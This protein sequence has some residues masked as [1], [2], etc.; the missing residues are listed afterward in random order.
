MERSHRPRQRPHRECPKGDASR[1]GEGTRRWKRLEMLHSV[2][3]ND[4][5]PSK[6][7][8][9]RPA[10]IK[11]SPWNAFN[12]RFRACSSFIIS[13][14]SR[15]T[16]GRP[17]IA[18]NFCVLSLTALLPWTSF[19]NLEGLPAAGASAAPA[20]SLR[21]GPSTLEGERTPCTCVLCALCG[22]LAAK[23]TTSRTRYRL[24]AME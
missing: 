20:G 9:D 15:R 23:G 10:S 22:R 1:R 2:A 13:S 5:T 11:L 12:R 24:I 7:R 19:T 18:C 3:R 16:R 21:F 17:G 4:R 8:G 6:R 14:T